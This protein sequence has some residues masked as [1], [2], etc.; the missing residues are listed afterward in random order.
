MYHCIRTRRRNRCFWRRGVNGVHASRHICN[1]SVTRTVSH[2]PFTIRAFPSLPPCVIFQFF[3]RSSTAVSNGGNNRNVHQ[4]TPSV[5]PT[6]SLS[7]GDIRSTYAAANNRT[8]PN[9][10]NSVDAGDMAPAMRGSLALDPGLFTREPIQQKIL[11]CVLC[12]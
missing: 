11:A 9:S 1:R 3:F 7:S 4:V 12:K 8:G 10:R 2:S 6:S 5:T